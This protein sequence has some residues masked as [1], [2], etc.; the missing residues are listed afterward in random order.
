[1]SPFRQQRDA[2]GN[3]ELAESGCDFILQGAG[4][5]MLMRQE[6]PE[7]WRGKAESG[8]LKVEIGKLQMETPEMPESRCGFVL[9]GADRELVMRQICPEGGGGR[10]QKAE[11]RDQ[12]ERARLDIDAS[13]EK[14]APPRGRSGDDAPLGLED[15]GWGWVSINMPAL[16]ASDLRQVR[17]DSGQGDRHSCMSTSNRI[18]REDALPLN[19]E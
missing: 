3:P 19:M 9:H 13:T 6:C 10:D 11:V 1:V 2:A 4:G 14:W 7:I 18:E 17:S 5:E 16:W 8:K 15:L 12:R